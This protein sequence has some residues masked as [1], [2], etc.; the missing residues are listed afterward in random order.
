MPA[1]YPVVCPYLFYKD[2]PAA[3]QFLVDAFGF[4][5]RHA[6][7]P[8]GFGHAEVEI[9]NGGVVMMGDPPNASANPSWGGIHVYVDDVDGH[10]EHARAAGAT[11]LT[12]PADRPYGDRIYETVDTEGHTWWFAAPIAR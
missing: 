9:G 3:L 1:D 11:I 10:C 5:V 6:P 8:D 2:G 7:S 4:R 12:E